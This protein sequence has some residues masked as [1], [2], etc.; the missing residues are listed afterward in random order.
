MY[1]WVIHDRHVSRHKSAVYGKASAKQHLGIAVNCL[2]CNE[3]L[4]T[5]LSYIPLILL[6]IVTRLVMNPHDTST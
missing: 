2:Y 1:L 5:Q 6:T 3:V 4:K